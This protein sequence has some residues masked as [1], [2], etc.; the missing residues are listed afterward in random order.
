LV[1]NFDWIFKSIKVKLAKAYSGKVFF[2]KKSVRRLLRLWF[3]SKGILNNLSI[4]IS[5]FPSVWTSYWIFLENCAR[6]YPTISV[7]N[8]AAFVNPT[9]L[10]YYIVSNDYSLLSLSFYINLLIVSFKKAKL[11]WKLE[12]SVYPQKLISEFVKYQ[13]LP[14]K[15]VLK[16]GEFKWQLWKIYSFFRNPKFLFLDFTRNDLSI[17]FKYYFISRSK[18]LLENK[19]QVYWKYLFYFNLKNKVHFIK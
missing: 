19:K 11:M 16:L 7:N 10:D 6:F 3:C 15:S 14:I 4:D 17:F 8:T 13:Y 2:S 1:S 9:L 5:F 12:F 18:F